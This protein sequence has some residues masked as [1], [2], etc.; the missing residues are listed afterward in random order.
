MLCRLSGGVAFDPGVY[1]A[2]PP[3]EVLADPVGRKAPFPPFIADCPLRDAEN[4]RYLAG[5]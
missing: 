1:V 5:G 4:C 2:F 3:A